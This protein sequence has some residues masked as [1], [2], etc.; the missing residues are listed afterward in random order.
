MKAGESSR[1]IDIAVLSAFSST[2]RLENTGMALA[3]PI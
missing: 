2:N 1:K 3:G